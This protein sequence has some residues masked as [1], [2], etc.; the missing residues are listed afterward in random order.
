MFRH[1]SSLGRQATAFCLHEL[2]SV[3]LFYIYKYSTRKKFHQKYILR[4]LFLTSLC[5]AVSLVYNVILVFLTVYYFVHNYM[6]YFIFVPL[7]SWLYAFSPPLWGTCPAHRIIFNSIALIIFGAKC[8]LWSPSLL[9]LGHHGAEIESPLCDRSS[10]PPL[11]V[12]W[13]L[14]KK[15]TMSGALPSGCGRKTNGQYQQ[16][17]HGAQLHTQPWWDRHVEFGSFESI[18]TLQ[19]VKENTVRLALWSRSLSK[20]YLRIQSVPQREHHTSPLQRSTG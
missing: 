14:V 3:P 9:L 19:L 11:A 1:V 6:H 8:K 2:L 13:Q 20:C 10:P 5:H 17:S 12:L 16:V 15:W 4:S 18:S 7:F